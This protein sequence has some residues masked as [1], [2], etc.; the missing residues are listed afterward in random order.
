MRLFELFISEKISLTHLKN[1]LKKNIESEILDS[2][3]QIHYK[4]SKLDPGSRALSD[5]EGSLTHIMPQVHEWLAQQLDVRVSSII[6][7]ILKT[8]TDIPVTVDFAKMHNQ[9]EASN[10][11]IK[12]NYSFIDEL[13]TSI[14]A[15]MYDYA[16]DSLEDEHQI[17]STLFRVYKSVD[18][19]YIFSLYGVEKTINQ[20]I[21]TIIHEM[22]HVVQHD[23]QLKVGR[24]RTEYRSY[25]KKHVNSFYD[26]VRRLSSGDH[27]EEDYKA[28]RGSPQEIAAFA[29]EEAYNFIKDL[30]I[31]DLSLEDVAFIRKDL[32]AQMQGYVNTQFNNPA[33]KEEYNVFK[34]FN[35]LLYQE[36]VRYI[37]RVE[38]LKKK[39]A[40]QGQ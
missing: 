31:D 15:G 29:A 3:H 5:R 10:R 40:R 13:T 35:K 16:L 2:V 20:M 9:G 17:V 21:S 22:V 25:L 19:Y 27:S 4:E 32:P 1:P 23:A 33:N 11:H 24:P 38:K 39:E 14:I 18:A 34:R 28:Y 26:S 12:L 37:D 7:T 8:I 30:G 36:I 6:E